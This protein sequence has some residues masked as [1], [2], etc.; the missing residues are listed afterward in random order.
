MLLKQNSLLTRARENLNFEKPATSA[1]DVCLLTNLIVAPQFPTSLVFSAH[2]MHRSLE[3][4]RALP[5]AQAHSVPPPRITTS[6]H[7]T[8]TALGSLS[9]SSFKFEPGKSDVQCLAKKLVILV[10]SL[11]NQVF[12]S[13]SFQL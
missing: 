6:I 7:Y 1:F 10:I 3:K 9:L 12:L 13:E 11:I 8:R 5:S 2:C 4:L